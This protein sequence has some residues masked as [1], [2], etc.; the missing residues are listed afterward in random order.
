MIQAIKDYRAKNTQDKKSSDAT[1]NN[2][3]K[4]SNSKFECEVCLDKFHP[5]QV[6][7]PKIA[8][9]NSSTPTSLHDIKFMCPAC[10]RSRRPRLETI[11]S[12][13]VS[14]QKLMVRLPEG[15]ALQSLTERALGWRDRAQKILKTDEVANA[16][17]KLSEMSSLD[18]KNDSEN[19]SSMDESANESE[20]EG[21]SSSKKM[22]LTTK[23]KKEMPEVKVSPKILAQLEELLLE[24]DV[25]EVAIDE[26]LHIWKILQASE[27]RRSK[28]YPDLNQLEL[29]LESVRDEK[30]RAKKKRKLESVAAAAE[31]EQISSPAAKKAKTSENNSS[32]NG[33]SATKRTSAKGGVRG[34]KKVDQSDE[35]DQEEQEDCSANPKCLRPVG[36]EVC[37]LKQNQL[38]FV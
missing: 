1:A 20:A 14:L 13:L 10:L 26:T 3:E 15:Q 36:K 22:L 27:P 16:L 25:L 34:K 38:P 19:D 11:L 29:E 31:A 12:L 8:G 21:G 17:N 37:N 9:K 5:S 6:P 32:S 24:G 30:I 23:A 4:G 2:D 33:G 18:P 7:L 28:Q 35:E